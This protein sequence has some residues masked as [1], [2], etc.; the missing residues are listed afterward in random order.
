MTYPTS[1]D[2][3][4]AVQH[5][6]LVFRVPALKHAKFVEDPIL[7]VPMP[8]SGNAAVVFKA[9]V[10]GEDQALRFFIREDASTSDH[11]AALGYHFAARSLNDCVARASWIDDAITVKQATWPVVQMQWVEGRTLDKYVEHLAGNNDGPA[12]NNLAMAWRNVVDR[13]QRAEFAHGD[14]QHGNVLIDARS[15]LRLVDFDGS[16]IAA[17]NGGAPPSETGHPNYQRTGREWGRWMDTFPG[18]VIYTSLL[19]L[20]CRPDLWRSLHDG[21]NMLF[22]HV[23]Y[24]PPFTTKAWRVVSEIRNPDVQYAVAR[25]RECCSPTWRA[26]DTMESLLRPV[27]HGAGAPTWEP[28]PAVV[29]DPSIPWW[30]QTAALG[31][32]FSTG[33]APPAGVPPQRVTLPPP[34]PKISQ[35]GPSPEVAQFQGARPSSGWYT[36][37]SQPYSGRQTPPPHRSSPGHPVSSAPTRSRGPAIAIALFMVLAVAVAA[38]VILYPYLSGGDA[39]F[40]GLIVGALVLPLLLRGRGKR[41]P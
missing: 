17:F 26:A 7:R 19:A 31:A 39:L 40:V 25:L 21:E 33:A 6:E 4:R 37:P 29:P 1:E 30:M 3:L 28:A 8:A 11:Y 34:P 35:P 2:Y 10:N 15:A 38:Y 13:L 41:A 12:L 27:V 36:P 22:S 16:W 32:A 14:L 9:A 5:P 24:A 23:D 20:S 18:I